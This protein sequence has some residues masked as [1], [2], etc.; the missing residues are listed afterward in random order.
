MAE[1]RGEVRMQ[2]GANGASN[3]D[4]AWCSPVRWT[5]TC[6]Y[7]AKNGNVI[8]GFDA[9]REYQTAGVPAHGGSFDGAGATVV[10]GMMY[11]N[12]GYNNA[13]GGNVLLA[14]SPERKDPARQPAF[15]AS[16]RTAH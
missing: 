14:F 9:N 3:G 8:W 15:V 11:V 1:R 6:A 7:D 16:A 5:D 13:I 10:G 12:A 2:R 4:P